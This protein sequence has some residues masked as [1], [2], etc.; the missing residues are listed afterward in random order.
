M[1]SEHKAIIRDASKLRKRGLA[2][3]NANC[4]RLAAMVAPKAERDAADRACRLAEQ[5]YRLSNAAA[6]V[7]QATKADG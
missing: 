5:R 4:N 3:L 6:D 2:L 1:E 7:L